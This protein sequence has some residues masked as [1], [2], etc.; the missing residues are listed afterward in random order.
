MLL[1]VNQD[2][3]RGKT[4]TIIIHA[5]TGHRVRLRT[6]ITAETR[7]DVGRPDRLSG[8]HDDQALGE[9]AQRASTAAFFPRRR[10]YAHLHA[11]FFC[12]SCN[13]RTNITRKGERA[14][15]LIKILYTAP[16]C[17][18][19]FLLS[20]RL[21]A[22]DL[23]THASTPIGFVSYIVARDSRCVQHDFTLFLVA[24]HQS[25]CGLG[26]STLLERCPSCDCRCTLNQQSARFC[27]GNFQRARHPAEKSMLF[28][29]SV[30]FRRIATRRS[31]NE[32]TL[33]QVTRPHARIF[34]RLRHSMGV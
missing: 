17:P 23:R 31:G 28:L 24:C 1:R 22:S 27:D 25:R 2:R 29:F 4:N 5:S 18:R 7:G 6:Q 3:R 34:R 33:V 13:I 26:R 20:R 21:S 10:R 16:P 19:W 32:S 8:G 30:F 12:S 9:V 11:P 15:R 14:T